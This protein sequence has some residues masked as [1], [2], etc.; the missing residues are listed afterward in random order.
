MRSAA[1]ETGFV[2]VSQ[3]GTLV[4]VAAGFTPA[5][6]KAATVKGGRIRKRTPFLLN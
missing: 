1:V 4:F 3:S 6:V 2:P 5:A